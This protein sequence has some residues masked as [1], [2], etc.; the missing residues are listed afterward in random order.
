VRRA[1]SAIVLVTLAISASPTWGQQTLAQDGRG[2]EVKVEAED[3]GRLKGIVRR[4]GSMTSSEERE[5]V[6]ASAGIIVAGSSLSGG[7]GYRRLNLFRNIDAEVEA[8][9]SIRMYQ[10]YRAAIG[11]L[12][13]RGSSVEFDVADDKITSLFN[14]SAR[15]S[16]GSALFAD[17]R[18]R[19]Y[20]RHTYYGTGINSLDD[21]KSDYALRGASIEGV[22]QW[23]LSP[24]F[25]LSAR[26][27]WLGLDVDLLSRRARRARVGV[28]RSRRQRRVTV[29]SASGDWR[30][31]DAAGVSLLPVRRSGAG[32]CE[33]RV[34]M[35]RASLC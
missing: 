17:I 23:Q 28:C 7:I 19:D 8:N 22:W 14:A 1:S 10:D 18:Y 35:A 26:G 11:R 12:A 4:L 5:G 20:P 25:G 13:H 9:V 30:R 33:C 16:P 32:A 21:D 29:L 31:R 3:E 15:K 34:S 27:G 2:K 24:T 6:S